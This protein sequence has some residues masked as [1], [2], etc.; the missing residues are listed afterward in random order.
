MREARYAGTKRRPGFAA[1]R[2]AQGSLCC[3]TCRA[4]AQLAPLRFAQTVLADIPRQIC[5]ARRL[6]RERPVRVAPSVECASFSL[7]RCPATRMDR[8]SAFWQAR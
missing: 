7:N 4:A 2:F 1:L 5:A 3:S 8:R 6:T